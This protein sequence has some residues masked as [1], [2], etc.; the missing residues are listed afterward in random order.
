MNTKYKVSLKDSKQGF[1]IIELMLAMTFVATLLISIA[2]VTINVVS[3]YQRG[4][5]L[6]AVNNVGRSLIE[7]LTTAINEAPAVDTT[8]LCNHLA[9]GG[10]NAIGYA[11][12]EACLSDHAYRYVYNDRFNT[13]ENREGQDGE[14]Q[15]SGVFCTGNHSYLWNT[16]Y[17]LD[18]GQ[19]TLSLLYLD[20]NG[21]PQTIQASDAR[22]ISI[23]DRTYRV[24]S[25]FLQKQSEDPGSTGNWE[26]DIRQ[27]AKNGTENRI[28]MPI[29]GY[30]SAFDLDLFLYEF[31]V[32]PI[33]QDAITLRT[34]M[35]GNFILATERGGIDITTTGDYCQNSETSQLDNLGAEFNYCAINKFNFAARTAGV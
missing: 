27:E 13:K 19:R 20:E 23:P 28:A 17:G 6:K 30:L 2:V 1:T 15:Y 25:A 7:E 29:N 35:T 24:C 12:T 5:A 33:S 21:Q 4:L 16:E 14:Y 22:L 26:L 18:E 32:Q 10:S 3:I 11:S 8:S 31:T 34:Y 9:S